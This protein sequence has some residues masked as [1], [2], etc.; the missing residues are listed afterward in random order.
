MTIQ[1]FNEQ[2]QVNA[3]DLGNQQ[4]EPT[5]DGHLN[6]MST[7]VL[8]DKLSNAKPNSPIAAIAV[9]RTASALRDLDG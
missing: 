9:A 6:D 5:L 7:L 4:H 8:T 1:Q 2:R 3:N